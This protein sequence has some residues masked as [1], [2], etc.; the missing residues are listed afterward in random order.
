MAE[1]VLKLQLNEAP[2]KEPQEI[3]DRIFDT[4]TEELIIGLCGPIG[5]EIHLIS[6]CLQDI[7]VNSYAYQCQVIRLSDLIRKHSKS[8]EVSLKDSNFSQKKNLLTPV[9]T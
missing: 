8:F 4:H 9:M 5:T 7:L 2:D 6:E 1:P 3:K